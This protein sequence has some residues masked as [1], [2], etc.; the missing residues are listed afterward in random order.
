MASKN[1]DRFEE[2]LLQ[3]SA[4]LKECQKAK[5]L[6]SCYV[7]KEVIGC[8]VRKAYV[9]AVYLSMNRGKGGGFEF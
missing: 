6:K 9:D 7:C 3:K 8:A 5:G 4:K 2:E 1:R